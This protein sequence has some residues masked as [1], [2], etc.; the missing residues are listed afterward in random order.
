ML[1][2]TRCPYCR[3]TF[4]VV[5]DQ[6]KIC[7]GI[8]RCGSCRQVFN[9][10]EQ[11][12]RADAAAL[13]QNP[14]PQEPAAWPASADINPVTIV[15]EAPEQSDFVEAHED[16][17]LVLAPAEM[18]FQ[19]T[20]PLADTP[21]PVYYEM[22]AG[23]DAPAPEP[24]E[25]EPDLVL[26]VDE[27]KEPQLDAAAF[28]SAEKPAVA[29]LAPLPMTPSEPAPMDDD[30]EPAYKVELRSQADEPAFMQRARRQ[31]RYGRW[32]RVG[33]VLLVLLMLPALLLQIIDAYH[34]QIAASFPLVRP[35]VRQV[36]AVIDC[37]SELSAQIDA[38][39]VDSSEL[40]APTSGEKTFALNLLLRN[41]SP[42]AQAWPHV[43]LTLNDAEEKPVVRRVFTAE[44]YLEAGMDASKGF[45]AHSEQSLKLVFEVE[46]P[47][48]PVG[49]R[50][51]LFYP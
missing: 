43:E 48:K 19:H 7:N 24:E 23:D 28:L 32:A 10:I 34:Q 13:S 16:L 4:R 21:D 51:Y 50:V 20:T 41:R 18:T 26:H 6:L 35:V 44:E 31:E 1:L 40:H 14:P 30:D 9:G 3:T 5:Q 11:L 46:P 42:L 2:A 38:V 33:M 37:Q 45:A 12:Q 29:S 8:V 47:L 36:C 27:R 22:A 15:G 25:P 17:N 39:S 49:Y